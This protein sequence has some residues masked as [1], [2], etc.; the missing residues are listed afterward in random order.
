MHIINLEYQPGSFRGGLELTNFDICRGLYRRGHSITLVYF[1]KGNLLRQYEEFCNNTIRINGYGI[2]WDKPVSSMYNFFNDIRR[3][4]ISKD[5]V[6]YGT[7]CH[8]S[9]FGSMI[10]W[11]RG[12][13]FVLHLRMPVSKTY[14]PQWAIG[15][16]GV[17]RFIVV[18][19][20]IR[21]GWIKKGF[22]KEKIIVV[23]NGIDTNTF[24][25]PREL[26][27]VRKKWNIPEGTAVITYVGRLEEMK[28]IETLIKGFSLFLKNGVK[29]RLLI[30]G[31]HLASGEEY[32]MSLKR[33]TVNLGIEKY[34]DFLGHIAN[35]AE[36]YQLSDVN[37]VPS[38]WQEP[39]SRVIIESMSCGVPVIAS[40]TGGI[41]E[42]LTGEF[43][44][45]LFEPGNEQELADKLN[46]FIRWRENDPKLGKRC[47]EHIVRNFSQ[48]KMIDGVERVLLT[49]TNRKRSAS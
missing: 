22:E 25:P 17:R 31:K 3:I 1:K 35:P 48:E 34:V 47:R 45:F 14:G 12:A 20:H 21:L 24:K 6:V 23:H 18:S 5:S 37:V 42:A 46:Y 32:K 7:R 44:N 4:P 41:P 39:F 15:F 38:I 49:V 27:L 29:V 36:V 26:S 2:Y 9:L 13:P 16:K 28:G 43:Q 10:T 30:A 11:L 40:L 19:N 33:L 8:N